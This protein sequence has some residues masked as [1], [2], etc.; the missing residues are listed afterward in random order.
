MAHGTPQ[1][2]ARHSVISVHV[3]FYFFKRI[4]SM[5]LAWKWPPENLERFS[6]A[7]PAFSLHTNHGI[8]GVTPSW[9]DVQLV[10]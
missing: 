7:H 5:L 10:P 3:L 4:A 8:Y 1:W 9:G 2:L 6:L